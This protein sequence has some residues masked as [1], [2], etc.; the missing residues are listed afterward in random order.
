MRRKLRRRLRMIWNAW[1]WSRELRR[2]GFSFYR[3]IDIAWAIER[4]ELRRAMNLQLKIKKNIERWA[5]IRDE[6]HRQNAE[7]EWLKANG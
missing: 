1:L 2:R 6:L 4:D 7:E 3:S 5:M